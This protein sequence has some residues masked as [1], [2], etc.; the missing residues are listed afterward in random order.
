MTSSIT[1]SRGATVLELPY[2][3]I[4]TDE[5]DW[6]PVQQAAEYSVSGALII[7]VGL[8]QAGRPITL[9]GGDSFAW[10]TRAVADQLR[11]WA[12]LPG[13]VFTLQLRGTSRSVVFDH[14]RGAFEARALIPLADVSI[15]PEMYYV[16]LLRLMEV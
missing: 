7:D 2:D 6:H 12:A 14:G 10:M 8:R 5:Y 15:V 1:L 16:P 11:A 4:W 9:E 3:L 13:E